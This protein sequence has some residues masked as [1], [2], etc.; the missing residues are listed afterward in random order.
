MHKFNDNV[1]IADKASKVWQRKLV[2]KTFDLKDFF[3]NVNRT[4][5]M[6]DIDKML[7]EIQEYDKKARFF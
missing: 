5:F 2:L 3:T 1:H 6:M 4:R 7:Q